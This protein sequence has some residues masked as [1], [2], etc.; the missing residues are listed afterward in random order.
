MFK[1]LIAAIA[2]FVGLTSSAYALDGLTLAYGQGNPS[3]LQGFMAGGVW[4]WNWKWNIAKNIRLTGLWEAN[5]GYW[6]TNGTADGSNK[7]LYTFTLAPDLKL[8]YGNPYEGGVMYYIDASVGPSIY[9]S[10]RLANN[11]L[12]SWWGFEQQYGG[13]IAFG[14]NG[15]YD[16]SYHYVQF[17][18]FGIYDHNDGFLANWLVS[19][20]YHLN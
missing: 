14:Q 18:N 10:Q 4:N 13:G 15:Q 20:T 8:E 17:S 5:V 3:S 9:T 16:F 12:G 6:S 19:F 1:K 7:D 2:I 11:N